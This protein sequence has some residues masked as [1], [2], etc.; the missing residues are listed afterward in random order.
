MAGVPVPTY[1]QFCTDKQSSLTSEYKTI[2]VTYSDAASS[3]QQLFK[4]LCD[5]EDLAS[6]TPA[7]VGESEKW[8]IIISSAEEARANY[9]RVLWGKT[10]FS[11]LT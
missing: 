2:I 8:A 6:Y 3:M 1:R 10:L 4:M 11:A 9:C 5:I 7:S